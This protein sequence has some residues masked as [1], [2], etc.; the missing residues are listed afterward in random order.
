MDR[1]TLI[2]IGLLKTATAVGA[3]GH[4]I[5][6]AIKGA[7]GAGASLGGGIAKGLGGSEAVGK[8]IGGTAVVGGGLIGAKRAKNKVDQYRYRLQYGGMM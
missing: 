7:V 6:K 8:A 5:G 1:G 2:A 4:V 3:A